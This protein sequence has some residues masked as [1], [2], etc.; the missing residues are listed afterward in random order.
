[1]AARRLGFSAAVLT[2]L[3]P[4]DFHCLDEM[5]REGIDVY[6]S[7]AAQTTGI[8]NIYP[9]EDMDRR[10]CHPM[11]S[12]GP[13]ALSEVPPVEARVIILTPLMA[14]EVPPEIVRTLVSRGPVGL[15][16]Q[17]FVRVRDGETLVTRDWPRKTSDLEGV[18]YLKVDDA[19]AQ[20]LTGESDMRKAAALLSTWGPREVV[21]TSAGGVLVHTRGDDEFAPFTP[22]DVTGRTGRGDT[23][24]STYVTSRLVLPPREA[25][26]LAAAVT[27]LKME[28]PG[29]YRGTRRDAEAK[30]AGLR[31]G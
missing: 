27:S 5:R 22:R 14:G 4:D 12:A 1:M 15:D 29:P 8:E 20:I 13:F 11:G 21:I 6:A 7:P 2:Q 26:R 24:F 18:T 9:T 3:H 31:A 17:G 28:Q 30:A 10:I 16:V 25:C 19:E 23:C